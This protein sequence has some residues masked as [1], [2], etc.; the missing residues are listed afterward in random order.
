MTLCLAAG[1]ANYTVVL[2]D[3][4]ITSARRVEDDEFPKVLEFTS[5]TARFGVTFSGLAVAPALDMS[6]AVAELLVE[7]A[8]DGAD[9]DQVVSGFA[10]R[11]EA[12]FAALPGSVPETAKPTVVLFAGYKYGG[13]GSSEI[14]F[15]TATN[16]S[17]GATAT[18][19]FLVERIGESERYNYLSAIGGWRALPERGRIE[20]GE[21]LDAGKPAQAVVGKGVEVMRAAARSAQARDQIGGQLLSLVIPA[22]RSV[23]AS[24]A[25]HTEFASDTY[26][27]PGSVT[28]DANGLGIAMARGSITSGA[29]SADEVRARYRRAMRGAPHDMTQRFHPIAIPKV[30]RNQPCPCGSGRKYKRCHGANRG[31]LSS[32]CISNETRRRRARSLRAHR[33]RASAMGRIRGSHRPV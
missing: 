15:R 9:P 31:S 14:L 6:F 7:A 17:S 4:R 28:V 3:R 23:E 16:Q 29:L 22:D 21:L 18:H 11:L 10:T 32:P 8:K 12:K 25:Y 24:A 30:G 19:P 27:F 26:F 33:G 20:L 13:D 5:P 1:G 2:A